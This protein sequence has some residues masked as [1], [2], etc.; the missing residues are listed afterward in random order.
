MQQLKWGAV[1]YKNDGGGG[2]GNSEKIVLDLHHFSA[3]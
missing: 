3:H 1:L 2:G